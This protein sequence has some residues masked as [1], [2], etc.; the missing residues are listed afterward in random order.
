M[1]SLS[2][3]SARGSYGVYNIQ[4]YSYIF[5]VGNIGIDCTGVV[6]VY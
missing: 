6:E 3:T 2:T 5:I 1:L 4:I